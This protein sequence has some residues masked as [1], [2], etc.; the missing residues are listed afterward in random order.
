[1]HSS[2]QQSRAVLV[3][4]VW[5]EASR[6][7]VTAVAVAAYLS[8]AAETGGAITTVAAVAAAAPATTDTKV[9]LCALQ[10]DTVRLS[11]CSIQRRRT[12]THT[13]RSQCVFN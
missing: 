8:P 12:H 1:M 9:V 4:V 2:P 10:A 5:Q 7:S 13:D 3:A 11:V 6:V